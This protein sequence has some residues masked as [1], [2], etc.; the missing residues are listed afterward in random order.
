MHAL[1]IAGPMAGHV[2]ANLP[3]FAAAAWH[4][5]RLG[6]LVY[7]PMETRIEHGFDP[8]DPTGGPD[9]DQDE[10]MRENVAAI[11]SADALILLPGSE[12]SPE[13]Q[14]ERVLAQ[15]FGLPEFALERVTV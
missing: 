4:L 7:S 8:N 9:F 10:V 15:A 3:A 5:R 2:L 11:A 1:Y 13:A 6:A 14:V 12:E